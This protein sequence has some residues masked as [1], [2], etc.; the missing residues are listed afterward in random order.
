[1][2]DAA[3]PVARAS[4]FI[5]AATERAA[6]AFMRSLEGKYA[7]IEGILFGSRAR[8]THADE[9]DADIAVVL[10]GPRGDRYAVAGEMAGIA[11]D[12]MLETGVLVEPLPIWAY[13]LEWP[14][15]FKNP[16]LIHAIQCD[17]LRL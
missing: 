15:A 14:E 13:E 2:G 1:M 17:G 11:F 4:P 8:G 6:R 5:D 3:V 9:S 12:V 16:A 7:V 10:D